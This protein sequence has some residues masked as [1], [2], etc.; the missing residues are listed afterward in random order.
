MAERSID[1]L[2]N[3]TDAERIERE[4]ALA[5]EAI[6]DEELDYMF[7]TSEEMEVV[8]LLRAHEEQM[9]GGM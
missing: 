8:R 9:M 7:R 3:E 2:L 1:P 4:D 6:D 5:I